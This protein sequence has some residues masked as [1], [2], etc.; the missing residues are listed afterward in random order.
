MVKDEKRKQING[1]FRTFN[2]ISNIFASLTA[3]GIFVVVIYQIIGRVIGSPAPWTE[4]LT[5]FMFIWMVFIGLGI[6]FRRAESA[7]VTVFLKYMPKCIQKASV[8]IYA[9]GTIAFFLFMFYTGIGLIQ[10]QF[11]MNETSSTLLLPMWLIGLS[12]PVSALTGILNVI[13]SI[14]YER[15]LL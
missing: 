6:G 3:L 15:E 11:T 7:R 10:Q 5:R 2:K 4:E 14:L 13:Q 1:L 9:T 12:I 8:A